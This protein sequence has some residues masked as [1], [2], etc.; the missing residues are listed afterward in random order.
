MVCHSTCVTGTCM[1]LV[2]TVLYALV[3]QQFSIFKLFG[4]MIFFVCEVHNFLFDIMKLHITYL[5]T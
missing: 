2:D 4:P 5:H 1:V 3:P